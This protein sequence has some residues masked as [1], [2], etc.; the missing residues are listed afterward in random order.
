VDCGD[1]VD[2]V[3]EVEEVNGVNG[4]DNEDDE[5]GVDNEDGMDNEDGVKDERD[6]DI[7][8]MTSFDIVAYFVFVDVG[9]EEA[10]LCNLVN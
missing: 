9:C 10:K 2:W 6:G 7:R 8:L 3:N 4:V 1:C 5:D